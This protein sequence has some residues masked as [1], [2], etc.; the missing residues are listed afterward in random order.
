MERV[1]HRGRTEQGIDLALA[2]PRLQLVD[3]GLVQ[4]AALI[5]VHLV[6]QAATAE[7]RCD[8]E[9]EKGRGGRE[10]AHAECPR[11]NRPNDTLS[12]EFAAECGGPVQSRLGGRM[13]SQELRKAGLKV[14]HPRMRILEILETSGA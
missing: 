8:S 12:A 6:D 3:L 9:R 11:R 13:E 4:Q 10:L 2:Q 14:T 5:D 1:L 7:Q